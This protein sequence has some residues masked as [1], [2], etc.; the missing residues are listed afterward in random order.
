M[1]TFETVL[2][3][4]TAGERAVIRRGAIFDEQP[5]ALAADDATWDRVAAMLFGVAIGDAL[6]APT[7]G[8]LPSARRE[9]VGGDVRDYSE[10]IPI[11]EGFA[12]VGL[13]TDDT[14]LTFWTIDQLLHDGGQFRGLDLCKRLTKATRGGGR[15]TAAFAE[16]F[17]RLSEEELAAGAWS[18]CGTDS[19]SNGALMRI[20][21]ALLPHLRRPSPALWR[22]AAAL[23]GLTHRSSASIATCVAFVR[24]YWSLLA[25]PP[26]T[27]PPRGWF[28]ETFCN[29]AA[30][31]ETA[32][33][34]PRGG[35]FT[36]DHSTLSEFVKVCR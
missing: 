31:L 6:G 22:D 12:C 30:Q 29:T 7:E 20:T 11:S 13:P 32:E 3:G 1:A 34:S 18:Q 15:A 24:I 26:G 10:T 27:L 23:A 35:F 8:M 14:Q 21:P 9:A 25:M 16:A 4:L 19:A 2:E 28:A 36:S 5:Q 33:Y 17:G